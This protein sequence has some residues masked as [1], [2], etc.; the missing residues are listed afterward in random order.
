MGGPKPFHVAVWHYLGKFRF[1]V[2]DRLSDVATLPPSLP[3]EE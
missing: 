1:P 2:L 3:V